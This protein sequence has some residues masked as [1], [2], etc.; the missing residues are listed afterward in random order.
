MRNTTSLLAIRDYLQKKDVAISAVE[1]VDHFS[2]RFNKTTIYRV[3]SRLE[4]VGEIHSVLGNDA[5]TYYATCS[6]TCSKDH[7][8]HNHVHKQC[9]KCGELS[10]TEVELKTP[11]TDGFIVEEARVLLV[12]LCKN[13]Q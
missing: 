8:N 2:D 4:N 12:G 13:C 11:E 9:K 10:C 1:L 5:N 3:L 7:H 6:S